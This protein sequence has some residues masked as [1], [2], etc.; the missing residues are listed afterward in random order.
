[1]S[2]LTEPPHWQLLW[3][4]AGSGLT[5]TVLDTLVQQNF[6]VLLQNALA[7][8]TLNGPLS[9]VIQ[10]QGVCGSAL[11]AAGDQVQYPHLYHFV[12]IQPARA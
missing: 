12:V 11:Y 5:L 8:W 10:E 9:L 6:V 2:V 4:T 7:I 3:S 1:M